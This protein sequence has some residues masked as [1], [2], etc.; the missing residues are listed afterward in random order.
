MKNN[1][2]TI[3]ILC[4]ALVVVLSAGFTSAEKQTGHPGKIVF[5]PDDLEWTEGPET[6]PGSK[7]AVLDGDPKESGF[8]VM[9]MKLPAGGKIPPHIHENVER[10]T[11]ISGTFYLAE[12]VKPENPKVLPAGSYFSFQ[13]GMVHNA[14]ADEE[15]VVQISTEGPWTFKP[16]K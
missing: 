11:V 13:P 3:V 16:I 7:M 5:T 15:T 14:W 12:G 8:F 1:I 4:L 2:S 6:I 9:R 10:V